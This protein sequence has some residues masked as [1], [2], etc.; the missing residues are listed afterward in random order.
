MAIDTDPLDPCN[1]LSFTAENENDVRTDV[2]GS[3]CYCQAAHGRPVHA[4]EWRTIDQE[5]FSKISLSLAP[6]SPRSRIWY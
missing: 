3:R 5:L 4:C 2:L 1:S 6:P